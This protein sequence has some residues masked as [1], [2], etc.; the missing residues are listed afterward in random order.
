MASIPSTNRS[1]LSWPANLN[2]IGV[3]E[4]TRDTIDSL[5]THLYSRIK[6]GDNVTAEL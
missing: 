1:Y 4:E 6:D 5:F 3:T 2:D